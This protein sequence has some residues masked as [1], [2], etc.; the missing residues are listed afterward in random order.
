MSTNHHNR[1]VTQRQPSLYPERRMTFETRGRR[2][3]TGEREQEAFETGD[4]KPEPGVPEQETGKPGRRMRRRRMRTPFA[5]PRACARQR[6]VS[7]ESGFRPPVSRLEGSPASG[8]ALSPFAGLP[9]RSIRGQLGDYTGAVLRRLCADGG[10]TE[11]S[12][13][14]ARGHGVRPG[15]LRR[16]GGQGDL[17]RGGEATRPTALSAG[18]S[19]F[20]PRTA[21]GEARPCRKVAGKGI[22]TKFTGGNSESAGT[23][24]AS[25]RAP[26]LP[27]EPP[28]P[29]G[30]RTGSG[31][32][33]ATQGGES[34]HLGETGA[35]GGGR[36]H[37]TFVGR[38]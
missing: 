1:G 4:Q 17:C 25:P 22:G 10:A 3:E 11:T 8:F 31:W 37:K 29:A 24:P 28:P 23:V 6:P 5:V 14:A 27:P 2:P 34:L 13:E 33:H 30:S 7:T 20:P 16:S 38:F 21:P 9:I 36:T 32:K 15:R 35:R 18:R 26:A 19:R 12:G